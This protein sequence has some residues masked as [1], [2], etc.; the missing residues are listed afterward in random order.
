MSE[1][2]IAIVGAGIGGLVL[3]I[4]LQQRGVDVDV[5]EQASELDE[6]GAGIAL[7]ANGTRLLR[8]LGLG[9][10]LAEFGSEPTS[11]ILRDGIDGE[12]ISTLPLTDNDWYREQFGS[13]YYGI[14]RK[15][16]QRILVEALAEDTIK[17]GHRLVDID[18]AAGSPVTMTWADHTESRADVVVGADGIRSTVRSWLFGDTAKT[19]FSK[20]SGFRGVVAIEDLPSLPDPTSV[21]FWVG[22]G[23]HLLHFPIGPEY[24][25]VTFLAVEE[26]PKQWPDP[27]YWRTPCTPAEA[28]AP[29]RGWH[30]AVTEMIDAVVHSERWGLFSVEPLEAWHK[31]NVVLTGD[32]AH[33]M[34]PHHGQGANQSI[35][36]AVALA[37]ALTGDPSLALDVR[38]HDYYELRKPRATD[39]Q[40]TSWM[41]NKLLHLPEGPDITVRDEIFRSLETNL[42]WMHE[43]DV[44]EAASP[45]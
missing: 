24:K 9:N 11:A 13:P 21:Q 27:K 10:R 31:G 44:Q 4:A 29:F 41:T 16:L 2:K 15:S 17:L 38:L 7:W 19:K 6:I 34:L 42:K 45:A 33:G 32:A 35:E 25:Y 26:S 14:H 22:D 8:R 23:A 39:V 30:P 12:K 18:A 36:D 28:L 5:Y 37:D 40:K 43:Y 1:Q 20:T 3:A